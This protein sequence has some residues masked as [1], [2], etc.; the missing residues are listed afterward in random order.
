MLTSS[1]DMCTDNVPDS[2]MSDKCQGVFLIIKESLCNFA[3]E[4]AKMLTLGKRKQ[5]FF[6]LAEQH[7]Y[8][9]KCKI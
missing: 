7:L 6:A 3:I 2:E 9:Q 5:V 4:I 8:H 1:V